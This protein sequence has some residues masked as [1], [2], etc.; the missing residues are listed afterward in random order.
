MVTDKQNTTS[1]F[2]WP[3]I[4]IKL[5]IVCSFLFYPPIFSV[6]PDSHRSPASNEEGSCT[7]AIEA[8][9]T[10][11]IEIDAEGPKE[12]IGKFWKNKNG[13]FV[14]ASYYKTTKSLFK[15]AKLLFMDINSNFRPVYFIENDEASY[16]KIFKFIE[17]KSSVDPSPEFAAVD[18]E[19]TDW[20][21][22]YKAYNQDMENLIS[23]YATL[24]SYVGKIRD[25]KNDKS[26]QFP[27][28]IQIK[29]LKEGKEQLYKDYM[30]SSE[31]LENLVF[32]LKGKM[33][34]LKGTSYFRFGAIDDRE[35]KQA[36]LAERLKFLESEIRN[37]LASF[38]EHEDSFKPL[39]QE[40]VVINR[41]PKYSPT[42]KFMTKLEFKEM[43]AEY[44]DLFKSAE[45]DY[46][47]INDFSKKVI[48]NLSPRYQ[49]KLGL[50]AVKNWV[51]AMKAGRMGV[52][53]GGI[54]TVGT[55][56]GAIALRFWNWYNYD[57]DSEYN[58]IHAKDESEFAD[59]LKK[60][61]KGKYPIEL[62]T[63]IEKKNDQEMTLKNY[64]QKN[65]DDAEIVKFVNGIVVERRKYV[66][67]EKL[68]EDLETN[69]SN[70]IENVRTS[71]NPDKKK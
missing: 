16:P 53:I 21:T 50:N 47:Q 59:N 49:E 62:I 15:K 25:L 9:I 61:L 63:R 44:R 58:I 41:D 28:E 19:V 40:L 37:H 66:H 24:S 68:L 71:S 22:N 10:K 34:N 8:L 43:D 26:V 5:L 33:K 4:A 45:P 2:L 51:A 30:G 14:G 70:A 7:E 23:E 55:G 3:L 36:L 57:K 20:L 48:E 65:K 27:F 54:G 64:N 12:A 46:Q 31:D 29:L 60:Y 67:E 69:L 35:F 18:K 13:T 52:L 11:K 32:K 38:P 42:L 17:L 39:L 1:Q 6:D 56:T